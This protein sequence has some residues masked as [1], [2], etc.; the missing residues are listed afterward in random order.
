MVRM[1]DAK[2]NTPVAARDFL[3]CLRLLIAYAIQIGVR[4]DDPTIG[5]RVKLPKTD[6]FRTWTGDDIAAFEAAYP[7][8]TKPRLALALLL[9]TGLR[10]ADAVKIGR[11]HVRD[12]VVRITQQKNGI[13]VANPITTE[14]AEAINTTAPS[15]H[16]VFLV[17]EHGKGFTAKGFG[18]WF[19]AQC[20]RVGLS[21]L[22]PHGVRKFAAT[23][24]ANNGA[25]ASE[26]MACFGWGSIKEA[27]RYTRTANREQ[28]ARD[29]V[30]AG[31]DKRRTL[32]V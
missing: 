13:A 12:G 16:V 17:N 29:A 5:V 28:L 9:E 15:A 21:G 6:G 1:V 30:N 2:A 11:G 26:L 4:K 7:V 25:T 27:E 22:S 20:D 18:K 23:R 19:S 14:L 31:M 3:R 8:G 24:M 10:C 32:T